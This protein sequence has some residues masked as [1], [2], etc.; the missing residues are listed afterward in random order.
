MDTKFTSGPWEW[1]TT[2][3]TVVGAGLDDPITACMLAHITGPRHLAE[4][5]A[6]LMAA[7]PNLLKALQGLVNNSSRADW[8]AEVID[9]AEEAI[10]EA[11]G[12]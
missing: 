12:T 6:R 3:I 8:P 7:A 9:A 4:A 2:N 11:I 5:N 10:G 1:K